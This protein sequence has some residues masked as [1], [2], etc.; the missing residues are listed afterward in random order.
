MKFSENTSKAITL[1]AYPV[2]W[3][4]CLV[5]FWAMRNSIDAAG[6][7]IFVFWLIIP[8]TTFAASLFIAKN[9]NISKIKWLSPAFFGI[10]YMLAEYLSFSLLNMVTFS[11]INRPEPMLIIYGILISTAGLFAGYIINKNKKSKRGD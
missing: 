5:Y 10:M 11:K 4:A 6:Y 9:N 2:I 1:A 7:S 3:A 8:I